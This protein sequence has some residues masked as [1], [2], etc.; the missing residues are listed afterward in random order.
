MGLFYAS[1]EEPYV[2]VL[3]YYKER[4]NNK[5]TI[6]SQKQIKISV[7]ALK[8]HFSKT[9]NIENMNSVIFS[10]DFDYPL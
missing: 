4:K 2:K 7:N 10:H 1:N 5:L 8:L 3:I 6:H 9:Y